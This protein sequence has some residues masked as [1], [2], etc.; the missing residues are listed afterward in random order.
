MPFM[1]V[2][3]LFIHLAHRGRLVPVPP[4][5]SPSLERRFHRERCCLCTGG[6]DCNRRR[7]RKGVKIGCLEVFGGVNG[8]VMG[9]K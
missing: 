2:N 1:G 9:V 8:L 3:R 7:T 4:P 6:I 5:F